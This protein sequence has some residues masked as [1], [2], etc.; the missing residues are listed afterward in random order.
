MDTNSRPAG[1]TKPPG[2]QT[3]NRAGGQR[4]MERVTEG[5]EQ[6]LIVI[7]DRYS[8][9]AYTL[10][11]HVLRDHSA[12]ED[13][14]QEVFLRLWRD[15]QAYNPQRGS[16]SAWITMNARH[17]AVDHWRKH[18]REAQI[19]EDLQLVESGYSRPEYF[20]DI[21]KIRTILN[22]LPNSQSEILEQLFW[23]SFSCRDRLANRPASGNRQIADSAGATIYKADVTA[24]H[25]RERASLI[26]PGV[27]F[28]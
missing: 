3:E 19:P 15:P 23:R 27:W 22:T 13:T 28:V 1:E 9:L 11:F 4:L 10:A 14:T 5:D 25:D 17:R 12:A 7:Y 6:A 16:L 18:R 8:T 20:P 2:V 24:R 26:Q 21:E